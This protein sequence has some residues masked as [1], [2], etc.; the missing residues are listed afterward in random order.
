MI[1][2]DGRLTRVTINLVPPAVQA[3]DELAASTG[4]NRTDVINRALRVYGWF[5]AAAGASGR[6]AYL[7]ADGKPETVVIL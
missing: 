5:Y 7:G 3:L 6:L 4:G 2:A 1:V